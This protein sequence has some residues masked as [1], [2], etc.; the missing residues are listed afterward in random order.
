MLRAEKEA[1][2]LGPLL[3]GEVSKNPSPGIL[4][5]LWDMGKE[6]RRWLI[7]PS[8][9]RGPS[10]TLLPAERQVRTVAAF[11]FLQKNS[12]SFSCCHPRHP[13]EQDRSSVQS[14][15]PGLG[16]G[17]TV[18][19]FSLKLPNHTLVWQQGGSETV[20]DS[21]KAPC[22]RCAGQAAQSLPRGH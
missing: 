8:A 20:P 14:R 7:S 1:K 5:A 13:G 17:G 9:T 16:A 18:T 19:P 4:W 15:Q 11:I 10:L 6:I 3:N 22:G 12:D 2:R 21:G